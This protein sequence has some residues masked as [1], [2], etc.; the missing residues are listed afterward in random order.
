MHT[1]IDYY[2]NEVT[3]SFEDHPFTKDPKHVWIIC[4]Y[5]N[6][7]LLTKHKERG[8]EFPGGKVED[9][10]TAEQGAIREVEEE[11]G[12][13]ISRIEYIGQYIVAGRKENLVKNIYY[14]TILEVISQHTYYET[15][16]PVLLSNI[17]SNV[18]QNRAFSFIMKDDVL[19]YSM[20]YI[21]RE[22][23]A[24]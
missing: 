16:G 6:E 12:G 9:G 14:A 8:L 23:E 1:F 10:E 11:T 5:K 20:E 24:E 15:E 22:Y 21:M 2:Q 7:W 3:L 18:K 4:K 17:P 19:T 13:I